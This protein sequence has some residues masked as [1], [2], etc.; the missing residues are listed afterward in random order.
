MGCYVREM[1]DVNGGGGGNAAWSQMAE[2]DEE[3]VDFMM[4]T[5]INTG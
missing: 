4:L 2:P 3:N 5:D 1:V